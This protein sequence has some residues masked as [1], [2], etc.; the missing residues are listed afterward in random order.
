[1]MPRLRTIMAF[2]AF[3]GSAQNN[4]TPLEY[5]LRIINAGMKWSALP[6]LTCVRSC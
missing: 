1:M 5:M 4:Q 6:H 3:V 2:E